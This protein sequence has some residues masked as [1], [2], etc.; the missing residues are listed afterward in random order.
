MTVGLQMTVLGEVEMFMKQSLGLDQF[1]VYTGKARSGVGFESYKDRTQELTEEERENY[2]ILVSKYLTPALL[3]GYTTSFDAE[4]SAIFGQIDLSRRF[5]ITYSRRKGLDS[6]DNED[7][8]GL[9]YKVS[10]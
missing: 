4:E 8:Y 5:N 1:R 3:F 7:W 9:E 2:N 6:T 10:F